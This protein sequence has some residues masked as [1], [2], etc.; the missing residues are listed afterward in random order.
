[1]SNAIEY[2]TTGGGGVHGIHAVAFG[3]WRAPEGL[4]PEGRG[5]EGEALRGKHCSQNYL[6][7]NAD[8]TATCRVIA[9]SWTGEAVLLRFFF[10]RRVFLIWL[11]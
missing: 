8:K 4:G 2:P 10:N 1:M 5:P 6:K 3:Y 7:K 9:F 11:Q